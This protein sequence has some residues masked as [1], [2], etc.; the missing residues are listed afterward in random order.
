MDNKKG[1]VGV[2]DGANYLKRLYVGINDVARRIIKGYV[3]V[4]GVARLCYLLATRVKYQTELTA[5]FAEKIIPVGQAYGAFP[6][7]AN[8]NRIDFWFNSTATA[9]NDTKKK[10]VD[11]PWCAYADANPSVYAS[12]GYSQDLL[13]KH[14]YET[15]AAAG[16]SL[17]IITSDMICDTDI[18]HTLGHAYRPKSIAFTASQT[19]GTS[20]KSFVDVC[21]SKGTVLKA[22]TESGTYT[23]YPGMTLIFH[24]RYNEGLGSDD[25]G[26]HACKVII[27]GVVKGYRGATYWKV[28]NNIKA[29]KVNLEID[30]H[31]NPLLSQSWII[32]VTTTK[33]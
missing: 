17:G 20:G 28:P 7:A 32:T 26:N 14:W 5:S 31:I 4:D 23:I 13:A 30:D 33:L 24:A 1:Y 29:V 11:Y 3:G 25:G 8:N 21:D 22:F 6:I 2:E 15:G 27:D 18:D 10:Y 9:K 19:E 16:L 12:Y